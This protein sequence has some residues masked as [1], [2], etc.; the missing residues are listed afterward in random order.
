MRRLQRGV[1]VTAALAALLVLAPQAGAHP[2]GKLRA[3]LAAVVYGPL[4]PDK[5]DSALT[6]ALGGK[7]RHR[8]E[9]V[10]GG[11]QRV[12]QYRDI[13]ARIPSASSSYGIQSGTR[14]VCTR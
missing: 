6:A 8:V 7:S 9:R 3:D 2:S 12:V 1:A 11:Y 10:P 5:R 13:D 14:L 4:T